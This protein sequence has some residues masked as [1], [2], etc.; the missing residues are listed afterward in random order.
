M[1]ITFNAAPWL[2]KCL[3]S[4]LKSTIQTKIIIIDNGSTDDTIEIIKTAF[5]TVDLIISEK[6]IGFGQANNIGIKKALEA[7]A[8]Y[9]FL[10]NQDAWIEE[11]TIKILLQAATS[12]PN[13][14]IISPL[15]LNGAGNLIDNLLFKNLTKHPS[16]RQLF[17]DL[18][19]KCN[20]DKI[21]DLTYVNAACW[22]LSKDCI[23]KVGLFDPIFEHYGE[24]NNYCH[25]VEFHKYKLGILTTTAIYHDR[26][27]RVNKKEKWKEN[28]ELEIK[29]SLTNVL[30]K[31]FSL[32]YAKER[33]KT[34]KALFKSMLTA[35]KKQ[36]LFNYEKLKLMRSNLPKLKDSFLKNSQ[37]Y[38]F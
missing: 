19:N 14:G 6:N 15:H 13:Y 36:V 10:L 33:K 23:S 29:L 22:L 12:N 9:V 32:N 27:D 2:E 24:D 3:N 17:S 37:P 30:G 20:A 38:K 28:P 25:R 18:F 34:Y 7:G 5:P 26:E 11:N 21:Y 8:A 31:S 1:I 16:G 35:N 4:L